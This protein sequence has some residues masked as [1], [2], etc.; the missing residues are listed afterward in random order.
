MNQLHF[1][2]QNAKKFLVEFGSH[3]NVY[4]VREFNFAWNVMMA[5]I[6]HMQ[7]KPKGKYLQ[8]RQILIANWV[9]FFFCVTISRAGL[10]DKFLSPTPQ[11]LHWRLK[12][13]RNKLKTALT[14]LVLKGWCLNIFPPKLSI[15]VQRNLFSQ[16]A[17][18]TMQCFLV[19]NCK[20][21]RIELSNRECAFLR[22]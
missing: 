15:A 11:H 6:I 20:L 10:Y 7:W 8:V 21:M 3:L 1:L 9:R 13:C 16:R 14:R 5:T 19:L 12:L 18:M 2:A 4:N 17:I 22:L